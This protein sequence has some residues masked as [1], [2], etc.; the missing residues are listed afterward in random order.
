MT[1]DR[2]FC[3]NFQNDYLI[4]FLSRLP[5]PRLVDRSARKT[6]FAGSVQLLRAVAGTD[7]PRGDVPRGDVLRGDVPR[8]RKVRAGAK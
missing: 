6:A 1:T 2:D 5:D 4:H 7:V 3:R 8:R